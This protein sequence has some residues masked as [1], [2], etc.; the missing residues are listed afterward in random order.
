MNPNKIKTVTGWI[1]ASELQ[2]CYVHEHLYAKAT[3]S[4]V[5]NN[6]NMA[7]TDLSKIAV[8]LKE[9]KDLGG[10]CVVEVTTIDYGRDLNKLHDLSK[11][12][13]VY[14]VG[15]GGFNKGVFNREFLENKEVYEVAK[16][17]IH[18]I[19]QEIGPGVLKIG[20]SL[21]RIDDWELIGLKAISEAHKQTGIPITT[22]TEKGTFASQQLSLFKQEGVQPSAI[23]IGH[24]DQNT[25]FSEHM[26]LISQGAFIGYDSIPKTKYDTKHRAIEFIA[27]LATKGLH[28]HVLV[29]GD[30][31]RTNYYH[32]YGGEPGLA[33]LLSEFKEELR[34]Y[35]M[36]QDIDAEQVI[37]DIFKNN[38]A[39]ALSFRF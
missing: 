29:S 13:G 23:I 39:K 28:N 8:D 22:H 15:T 20:T 21:N 16:D 37:E 26:K 14:I 9:F 32:G 33:Y 18:E 4:I 1:D 24:Q 25:D 17:L 2:G 19:N 35:L 10:N 36:K 34:Y 31:A 12:S 38:P 6:P 27:H 5:D 7:V 11:K 3:Q 30:F